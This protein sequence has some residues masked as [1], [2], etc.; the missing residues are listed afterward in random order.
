[1]PPLPAI[2]MIG[3]RL[4]EIFPEGIENRP[5]VIRDIAAKTVFVMLYVGAV[6]AGD[7]W[8]RP[9][10]VTKMSDAQAKRAR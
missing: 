8:I 5:Y 9:D 7:V 6:E 1:M 2:H 10:Q 3:I 4:A